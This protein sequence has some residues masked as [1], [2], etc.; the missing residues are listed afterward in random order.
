MEEWKDIKGYE[1]RY[2]ISS[3]GRVKSV[4][5]YTID[6]IGRRQLHRG[7]IMKVSYDKN[8]YKKITF[9]D[10]K[11][12]SVHR[13]VAEAFIPNP[14]NYP[15]INHKDE[16]PSNNCVWVNE[17]GS[18]NYD[19]SNLEWC[20]YKYNVNYGTAIDRRKAN[21]DYVELAKKHHKRIVQSTLNDVYIKEWSSI[22][23][24]ADCLKLDNGSICK[25]L[26][27][28]NKTCGGYKW[29]YAA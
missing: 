3:D 13:L 4:D 5:V 28:E 22:K 9:Y 29:K 6:T 23:E 20:T 1:E 7:K 14:N 27:G 17:D 11:S 16:N 19:K 26:K 2:Q 15:I 18:I 10:G 24:A 12:Y 25:C 8:G 21:T